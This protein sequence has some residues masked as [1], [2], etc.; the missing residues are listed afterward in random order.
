MDLLPLLDRWLVLLGVNVWLEMHA[1]PIAWVFAAGLAVIV[2]LVIREACASV[3]GHVFAPLPAAT[4]R[5]PQRR[6]QALLPERAALTRGARG[7]RAPG[8]RMPR[9]ATSR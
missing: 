3:R 7:P 8:R 9:H 1:T 2:L 4:R 5:S 6:D